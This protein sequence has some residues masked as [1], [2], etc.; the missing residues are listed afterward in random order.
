MLVLS[1]PFTC[2][3]PSKNDDRFTACAKQARFSSLRCV[4]CCFA[5]PTVTLPEWLA[6]GREA[7][8]PGCGE[9]TPT[10]TPVPSPVDCHFQ[11]PQCGQ[12]QPQH[13]LF[14]SRT[15]RPSLVNLLLIEATPCF[16]SFATK[17]ACSLAQ[18]GLRLRSEDNGFIRGV[19]FQ[20]ADRSD[21]LATGTSVAL[22]CLLCIME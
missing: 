17:A 8:P 13:T 2:A 10:R 4:A 21:W 5:S 3:S 20:C 16:G 15:Q 22:A 14:L 11:V 6:G 18:S 9:I 7:A 1:E 19:L 12:M